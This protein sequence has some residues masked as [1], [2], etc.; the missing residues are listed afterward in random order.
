M[1]VLDSIIEGVREDLAARRLPLSKLHEQLSAAPTVIDAH[2]RLIAEGMNIIAEVKRSSPSKGSLA[3]IGDPKAL[4]AQYEQ[5]GAA[6]VSVLTE[7]R[8]FGGSLED[9][10]AVRSEISIPILRKDFMVDEYQF[11]EARAAGADVVLLIVAALSK[12]QLKDYYDLATELGMAVLVETHT[13]QEIEDAM[14]IEPRIIGV[15]A[16]NLKTLEID[17]STFGEL[18]PEIP[19]SVIRIA[20]SGISARSEVEIAAQA[21]AN[22]ILV[23]ETLVKSG[24]PR[25]AINHLLGRTK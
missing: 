10:V 25:S 17:L 6:V 24:D 8:R 21:G 20:E 16:R 14:A 12:N 1:S 23:G 3:A 11:L 15:N 18:I 13:R 4:A 5:A 9:L 22:A 2:P 7:R 19:S